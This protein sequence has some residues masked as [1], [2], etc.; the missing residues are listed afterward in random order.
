MTEFSQR[1]RLDLTNALS[2]NV[3]VLAYLFKSSLVSTIVQTKPETNYSLFARTQ[4][5]QYITGDFAQV[6]SNDSC[7]RTL[8]RLVFDQVAKLRI[9]M[10]PDWGLQRNWILH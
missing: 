9:S 5:L 6:R 7:G 8:A 2:S 4:C 10:F 3:E 1:L